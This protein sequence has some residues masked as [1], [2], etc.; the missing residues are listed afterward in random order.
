MSEIELEQFNE[1]M[2]DE[3]LLKGGTEEVEDFLD[4]D[5]DE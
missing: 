5:D 3:E 2:D 1:E 4:F